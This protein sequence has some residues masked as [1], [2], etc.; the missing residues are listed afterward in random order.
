[1]YQTLFRTLWIGAVATVA[2]PLFALDV[3]GVKYATTDQPRINAAFRFDA[4]GDFITFESL[5]LDPTDPDGFSEITTVNVSGVFFDSG[6]SG[7]LLSAT[8]ADLIGLGPELFDPD[9]DGPLPAAPI[10]FSDIGIG[11]TETF[12]V[13]KEIYTSIADVNAVVDPHDPASYKQD[14]GPVRF[15]VAEPVSQLGESEFDVF[16]MNMFLGKSVVMDLRPSNNFI[17]E[18]NDPGSGDPTILEGSMRTYVYDSGTP[19]N[20]ETNTTDPGV[21]DV[22]HQ[23]QLSYGDFTDYT[24]TD[25]ENAPRPTIAHNPFIGTAPVPDSGGVAAENTPGVTLTRGAASTSGSFL[26]DTG[27]SV[28]LLSSELAGDL[29]VTVVGDDI[30]IDGV[31]APDED[32]FSVAIEGVGDE[33]A[34]LVGIYLDS[35]TLPTLAGDPNDPDDPRHITY[36]RAPFFIADITLPDPEDPDD[37]T[38]AITLDGVIGMNYLAPSSEVTLIS[39]GSFQLP[40]PTD[41]TEGAY[42]F[43]VIDEPS[44]ILGLRIAG[45]PVPEPGTAILVLATL[46][47]LVARRRSRVA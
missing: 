17:R 46:P 6:A 32:V 21:P 40:F 39:V 15:Q 8:T 30:F 13:S 43:A 25:P 9:G 37:I 12:T 16:G 45:R 23:I 44:G 1:M 38:K 33:P 34:T 27:G 5:V 42:D 24:S 35:A 29:G 3:A 22:D 26:L 11:G 4:N 36:Q 28:S 14:Y 10:E 47:A 31:L 41:L 2:A 20:P 7:N 19:F 18:Q